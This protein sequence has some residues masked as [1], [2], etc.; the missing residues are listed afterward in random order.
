MTIPGKLS[1]IGSAYDTV[2]ESYA[3][4]LPD[5]SFEAAED[6]AMI[7]EFTAR[8]RS[9][10][11]RRVIDAGCGTGRMSAHLTAAG[12]DVTGVDLSPGMVRAARRMH[13]RL[14]FTVG[15]LASLPA[16]DGSADGILA[17]YS[18]IHSSPAE[19]P[20]I[21]REF[22]RALHPGGL[23][24]IAFQAGSGSRTMQRPYG[25]DVELRAELHAPEDVAR[26]F[27]D[28]GFSLEA[29]LVRAARDGERYPQAALLLRKPPA[30]GPNGR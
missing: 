4:A 16:S 5:T 24:L 17:W 7:E 22:R 9:T 12:L 6:M 10:P 29:Q 15:E 1:D 23:A 3:S 8:V 13:P 19:L 18:I 27:T 26:G 25:H 14:S 21:S 30:D 28:L 2:A 20:G 11:G